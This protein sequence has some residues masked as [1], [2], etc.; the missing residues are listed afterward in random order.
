MRYLNPVNH[1]VF[2][3]KLRPKPL[4]RG[5]ACLGVTHR[6]PKCKRLTC[7]R[8]VDAD[9]PRASSRG[10]LKIESAAELVATKWW[11]SDAR[12]Q[13]RRTRPRSDSPTLHASTDAPNETSGQA[14]LPAEF[15]H[16]NK[17]RKRN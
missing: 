13:S 16:I 7:V 8:R 3:R 12:D 15:K 2:E 4:G 1:R 5:H 9:L 6:Y 14:G 10:W 11:M 17:R